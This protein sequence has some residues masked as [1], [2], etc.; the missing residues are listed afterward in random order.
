MNPTGFLTNLVSDD[1]T[2]QK[3]YLFGQ[4]KFSCRPDTF[5]PT[6]EIRYFIKEEFHHGI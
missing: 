5:R 6:I 4:Y 2:G 3:Y 1:Q